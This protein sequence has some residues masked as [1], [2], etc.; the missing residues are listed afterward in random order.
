M[1]MVNA[2][3]FGIVLLAVTWGMQLQTYVQSRSRQEE[4]GTLREQFKEHLAWIWWIGLVMSVSLAAYAIFSQYESWNGDPLAKYY[5]PPYQGIGYFIFYAGTR[6]AVG[7]LVAIAAAI[8]FG[9][10]ANTSNKK[11]GDKF[12]E[13]EEGRLFA[14]GILLAGYPGL[15]FYVGLLFAAALAL[16]VSYTILKKGRTPLYF[17][18]LPASA[19]AI[20]I[21]KFAVPY[22]IVAKFYF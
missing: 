7:P 6:Y 14:L 5:L 8:L 2:F 12:L 10:W 19:C 3:T 9:G 20:L 13:E 16:T 1:Y 21:T 17:L 15:V 4:Q 22:S 11:F 18:W